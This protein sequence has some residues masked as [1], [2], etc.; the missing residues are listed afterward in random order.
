MNQLRSTLWPRLTTGLLILYWVGLTAGTHA[1]RLPVDLPGGSDKIAHFVAFAGLAFLLSW[2]WTTRR[3]L[4]PLGLIF[5]L[6]V[7]VLYAFLDEQT[8]RLVPGR[9]C[10]L[11]DWLAD[12]TGALIGISLFWVLDLGYR[13]LLHVGEPI[14]SRGSEA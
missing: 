9:S 7:A 6:G 13:R 14:P 12:V 8:Q 2:V 11:A 10:E 5:A 1:P 4:V 3:P